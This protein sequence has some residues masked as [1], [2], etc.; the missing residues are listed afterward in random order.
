MC[1]TEIMLV[2]VYVL[3]THMVVPKGL[4]WSEWVSVGLV[5]PV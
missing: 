5:R 3:L 2:N 1:D 4:L